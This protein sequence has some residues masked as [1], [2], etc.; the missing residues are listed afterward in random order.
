MGGDG[1]GAVFWIA[2]QE[3]ADEEVAGLE[4]IDVLGHG[5]AGEKVAACESLVGCGEGVEG[6]LEDFVGW[7]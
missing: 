3:A 2:A 6:F 7:A 5:K 4:L 1:D